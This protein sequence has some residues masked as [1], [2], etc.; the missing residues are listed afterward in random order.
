MPLV[1]YSLPLLSFHYLGDRFIVSEIPFKDLVCCE[2]LLF[3]SRC[4]FIC[5]WL[6]HYYIWWRGG[7]TIRELCTKR[8]IGREVGAGFSDVISHVSE[9]FLLYLFHFCCVYTLDTTDQIQTCTPIYYHLVFVCLC[10][11]PLA[12]IDPTTTTIGDYCYFI[13]YDTF[14]LCL[15]GVLGLSIWIK[16]L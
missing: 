10:S 8:F 15:K 7:R 3:G 12:I 13:I 4:I 6:P 11:N 2:I 1:L 16:I 14:P 9:I 5:R